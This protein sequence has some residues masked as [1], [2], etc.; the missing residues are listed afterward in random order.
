VILSLGAH[1]TN[2]GRLAVGHGAGVGSIVLVNGRGSEWK[3]MTDTTA[4]DLPRST[5]GSRT[6]QRL[7]EVWRSSLGEE[8][9]VRAA[10]GRRCQDEPPH[11][12]RPHQ[13]HLLGY[14]AAEGEAEQINPVEAE[15]LEET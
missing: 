15:R 14:E 2:V 3:L 1:L 6:T 7:Q 11:E 4:A 5:D 13:H 10:R 9:A 8:G 12:V